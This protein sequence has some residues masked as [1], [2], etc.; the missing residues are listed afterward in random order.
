MKKNNFF[1]VLSGVV[2]GAVAGGMVIERIS[3]RAL[4]NC[5]ELT[6]KNLDL[7]LLMN[8]WM[9]TKQEG[10][11]IKEYLEKRGYKSVAVYGLSHVGKCLLEE[12]KD[13]DIEIK[14]AVDK[15]ASAIYSDLQVYLPEDD[16]PKA[17]VMIVTAVYYFDDIYN[18]LKNKVMYPIVSLKDILYGLDK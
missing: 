3:G 7:F 11:H 12:L 10:R 2:I 16:L 13:C 5:R 1:S 18:N 8:K 9:T 14:Y 6:D 17:D 4:D 15:N